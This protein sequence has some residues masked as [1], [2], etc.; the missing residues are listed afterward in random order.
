MNEIVVQN[1]LKT[2]AVKALI[3]LVR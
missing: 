2:R 3:Y 1:M